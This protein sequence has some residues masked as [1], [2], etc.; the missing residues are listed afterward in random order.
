MK[1]DLKQLRIPADHV[2]AMFNQLTQS[3]E[4]LSADYDAY[5]QALHQG[6]GDVRVI[7]DAVHFEAQKAMQFQLEKFQKELRETE[8]TPKTDKQQRILRRSR[9]CRRDAKKTNRRSI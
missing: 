4:K 2:D 1:D 5:M 7:L 6:K 8:N 9:Y 3:V